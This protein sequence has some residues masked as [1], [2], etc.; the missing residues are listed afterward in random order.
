MNSLILSVLVVVIAIFHKAM[1]N[2]MR[3]GNVKTGFCAIWCIDAIFAVCGTVISFVLYRYVFHP[4]LTVRNVVLV[5]IYILITALFIWVTPSGFP[6]IMKKRDLNEEENLT[7]E[8]RLNDTLGIVRNCFLILLFFLPVLFGMIQENKQFANLTSWR[9]VEVCGGFCFVA[10]LIL[11]PMCL[12]QAIFWLR[13]LADSQNETEERLL[14][15][16][17]IRLQYRQRNRLL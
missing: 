6:L 16:Y 10:F 9:E 5:I 2:Y 8:Y 3:R 17:R 15:K 1:N 7:A 12:R 11:V 14:K 4:F 13:N